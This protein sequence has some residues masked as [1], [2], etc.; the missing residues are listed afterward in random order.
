M[1]SLHNIE[2]HPLHRGQYIGYTKTGFGRRIM[3][4]TGSYGRWVAYPHPSEGLQAVALYA[5]R[6][7]DMSEELK[8]V[9]P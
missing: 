7:A 6:L 1:K 8:K 5:Y 2:K 4:S 3:P 9:T